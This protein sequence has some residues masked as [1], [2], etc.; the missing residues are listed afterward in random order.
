MSDTLTKEQR[1]YCMSK[2]KSSHT[3]PELILKNLITIQKEF[4]EIPILLILRRKLLFLLMDAS[5]INAQFITKNQNQI[6]D[7][8]YP[9]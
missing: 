1:S 9:N 7:I 2:I 4:L 8:G 3:K 6:R 5:G